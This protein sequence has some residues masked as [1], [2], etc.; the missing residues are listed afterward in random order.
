FGGRIGKENL[1]AHYLVSCLYAQGHNVSFVRTDRKDVVEAVERILRYDPELV[2]LGPYTYNHDFA[3][4]I[5]HELKTRTRGNI[6]VVFGNVHASLAPETVPL[7]VCDHI[8]KGEGE[9]S[10]SGLVRDLEAGEKPP[11][12]IGYQPVYKESLDSL[13]FPHRE[14]EL[15]SSTPLFF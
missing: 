5:A 15:L 6:I 7:D 13:P 4:Q 1:G 11:W 8:I 14:A 9:V 10:L 12:M 2:A 3:V